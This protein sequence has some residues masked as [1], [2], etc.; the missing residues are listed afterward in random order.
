MNK[1]NLKG[2]PETTHRELH[3]KEDPQYDGH[4]PAEELD[5]V[6]TK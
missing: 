1:I 2:L 5:Y 3:K 6:V 4:I